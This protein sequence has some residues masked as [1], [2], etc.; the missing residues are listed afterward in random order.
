M[1]S[2]YLIGPGFVP[3]RLPQQKAA[4]AKKSSLLGPISPH[5]R[6]RSWEVR[7]PTALFRSLDRSG[8]MLGVGGI[9]H[10]PD[11]SKGEWEAKAP[12][13]PPTKPLIPAP[14][15]RGAKTPILA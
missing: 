2:Q 10:Y 13:F 11:Y 7:Y 6:H 3:Q 9:G 1:L 15:S 14:D 8:L 4:G 5:P 12:K